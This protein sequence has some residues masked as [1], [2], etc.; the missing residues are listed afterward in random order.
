MRRH[1][2]MVER[3]EGDIFLSEL[4]WKGTGGGDEVMTEGERRQ[5]KETKS[6][7]RKMSENKNQEMRESR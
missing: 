4:T 3:E 2:E 6:E 7:R 5:G 1:K